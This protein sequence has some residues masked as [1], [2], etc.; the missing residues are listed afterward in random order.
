VR[1]HCCEG[2][3][4][5]RSQIWDV[6]C[7]GE[8][9][10]ISMF[11]LSRWA[12]HSYANRA[13]DNIDRNGGTSYLTRGV[14]SQIADLHVFGACCQRICTLTILYVKGCEGL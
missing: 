14:V 10:V 8:D 4:N 11:P 9:I 1:E 7:E 5:S 2:E 12:V 13:Q 3:Q 6:G